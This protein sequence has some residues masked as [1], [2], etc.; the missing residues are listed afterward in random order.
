ME[1]PMPFKTIKRTYRTFHDALIDDPDRD[2]IAEYIEW[3]EHELELAKTALTHFDPKPK[4][5]TGKTNAPNRT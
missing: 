1:P 4:P 3:L 2:T 5:K